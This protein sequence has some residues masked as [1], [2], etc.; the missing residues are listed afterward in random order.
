MKYIVI[1]IL[2]ATI[3]VACSNNVKSLCHTGYHEHYRGDLELPRNLNGGIPQM[4]KSPVVAKFN[5]DSFYY[6][7]E[8]VSIGIDDWEV[9]NPIICYIDARESWSV[10]SSISTKHVG[11]LRRLYIAYDSDDESSSSAGC[12]LGINVN[13]RGDCDEWVSASYTGNIYILKTNNTVK[14]VYANG[15]SELIR[16]L[17]SLIKDRDV[18]LFIE[19]DDSVQFGRFCEYYKFISLMVDN[20][21]YVELKSGVRSQD[22]RL[23]TNPPPRGAEGGS[24]AE[25]SNP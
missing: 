4:T 6:Y 25:E 9:D 2:F 3:F 22:S 14:K 12:Y 23:P 19:S 13:Q 20:D 8:G 11:R 18:P 15:E 16:K 1:T 21:V 17:K 5:G 7:M 10:L 24:G